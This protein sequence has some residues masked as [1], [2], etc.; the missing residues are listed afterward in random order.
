MILN[1]DQLNVSQKYT[2]AAL[3]DKLEMLG[4]NL[5]VKSGNKG[6]AVFHKESGDVVG[7]VTREMVEDEEIEYILHSR[8]QMKRPSDEPSE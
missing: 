1:L 8:L 2:W 5:K 3:A 7:E 6:A 4:F